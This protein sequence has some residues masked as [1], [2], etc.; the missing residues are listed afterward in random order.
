MSQESTRKPTKGA[1]PEKSMQ[2]GLGCAWCKFRTLPLNLEEYATMA[3][4]LQ[5]HAEMAHGVK[6]LGEKAACTCKVP[7]AGKE[8]KSS[9]RYQLF[10]C[11]CSKLNSPP[12]VLVAAQVPRSGAGLYLREA[13]TTWRSWNSPV[14]IVNSI[15]SPLRLA[16][17]CTGQGSVTLN[18]L[19]IL[20]CFK[21][22]EIMF[23][24]K[25]EGLRTSRGEGDPFGLFLPRRRM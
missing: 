20:H 21:G 8:R 2:R 19:N 3:R 24:L 25:E 7:K 16:F 4:D 15:L 1:L 23:D 13:V 11:S 17:T 14:L 5:L 6:V 22:L 18:D 9:T 12:L 10:S